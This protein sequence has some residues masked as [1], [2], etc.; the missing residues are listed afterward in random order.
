MLNTASFFKFIG[1][2]AFKPLKSIH[3][4][5][6]KYVPLKANL[7]LTEDIIKSS[8]KA[9][10]KSSFDT[11]LSHIEMPNGN[12]NLK[13]FEF[14][15]KMEPIGLDNYELST[16]LDN[17]P[18]LDSS[19]FDIDAF[20]SFA[21]LLK[22][23]MLDCKI[24]VNRYFD[25]LGN[26]IGKNGEFSTQNLKEFSAIFN[27]YQKT[28][29]IV[30]AV[31]FRKYA[32]VEKI[33]DLSIQDKNDFL[34]KLI[35]NGYNANVAQDIRIL[36]KSKEEYQKLVQNL[37]DDTALH[38]TP[39]TK[40]EQDATVVALKNLFDANGTIS[41][42]SLSQ[43]LKAF[44][45]IATK[46]MSIKK[47]S[48]KMLQKMS[49]D[50]RFA[51]LAQ[52]DKLTLQLAA[53]FKDS[54]SLH[55]V[56]DV[57]QSAYNAFYLAEKLNLPQE[58]KLKLYS[59]IKNQN[60]FEK[61]LRGEISCNTFSNTAC[62]MRYKDNYKML[63]IF[64]TAKGI[65]VPQNLQFLQVIKRDISLIQNR[66]IQVP[67]SKIPKAS[68]F[69]V[70]GKS[71]KKIEQNGVTN[72]VVYLD[73]KTPVKYID[74]NGVEKILDVKDLHNFYHAT[75]IPEGI[76]LASRPNSKYATSASYSNPTQRSHHF[77]GTE[78]LVLN[79]NSNDIFYSHILRDADGTG[80]GK[81]IN[82]T[83]YIVKSIDKAFYNLS[84]V[85]KKYDCKSLEELRVINPQAAEELNAAILNAVPTSEYGETIGAYAKP[86]GVFFQGPKKGY[87]PMYS[88]GTS[89]KTK[90][91]EIKE[92]L[93]KFLGIKDNYKFKDVPQNLKQYAEKNDFAIFHLGD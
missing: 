25:I 84:D 32:T 3:P 34:T 18:I 74:E 58:N 9:S 14:L 67:Q 21:Q 19:K 85:F 5:K 64:S 83:R 81:S 60:L 10:K 41:E 89:K 29:D 63:E 6:I 90:S 2:K 56:R 17:A 44:P 16:I 20:G 86:Q 11:I 92:K 26:S 33:A 31:N 70:N 45:E 55:G 54:S 66:A 59:I 72:I 71:V 65:I 51:E 15:K 40:S 79:M 27:K 1:V 82:P 73:K 91:K 49:K 93:Y 4:E 39:L 75:T 13:T 68:N 43:I 77:F 38:F 46:D 50:G 88:F 78:G 8:L 80:F 42:T 22:K 47:S 7:E 23:S 76:E 69:I 28:R 62:E 24:G 36:P 53:L 12:Y 35:S 30:T 37:L 52:E 57:E 48:L 87:N 61:V